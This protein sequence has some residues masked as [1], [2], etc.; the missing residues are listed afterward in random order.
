MEPPAVT[1]ERILP[2]LPVSNPMGG[3][4]AHIDADAL[5]GPVHRL[6]HVRVERGHRLRGLIHDSHGDAVPHEG[7]GHLHADVAP[8]DYHGPPRL[9]VVEV[10]QERGPVIESLH[11]EHAVSVR[12]RQR[13]AHRDRAGRDDQGVEAFPVRPPGGQVASRHPPGRQ[14]DLLHLGAH[15][16]VDAI[17]PVCVRRTGDQALRLADVTGHPVRDAAG[18][19]GAVRSALERDDLDRIARDPLGL[20]GRAHPGRVRSDDDYSLGHRMPVVVRISVPA[21]TALV[22]GVFSAISASMAL[23]SSSTP[24]RVISPSIHLVL[25]SLTT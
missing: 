6:T 18:S 7:L 16:Q 10:R 17:A 4:G 24:C 20:R 3:V 11:A 22:T 25:L 9:G 23:W 21:R 5:H 8:A 2:S 12:A 1:T 13:R 15:P 19:L 14:V